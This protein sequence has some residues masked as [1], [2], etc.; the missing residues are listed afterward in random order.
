[1]SG[2]LHKTMINK[3]TEKILRGD[4]ESL[5]VVFFPDCRLAALLIFQQ[6]WPS[7]FKHAATSLLCADQLNEEADR[8]FFSHGSRILEHLSRLAH[9]EEADSSV[10]AFYYPSDEKPLLGPYVRGHHRDWNCSSM[11][12]NQ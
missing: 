7:C 4:T 11:L 8:Y 5:S 9:H 3:S 2:F 1:M 12:P 6:T 10:G